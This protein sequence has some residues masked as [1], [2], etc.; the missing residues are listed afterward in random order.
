MYGG[1]RRIY[2]GSDVAMPERHID[3]VKTAVQAFDIDQFEVT[4]AQAAHFLN[5]H[6][7]VCEGL[8]KKQNPDDVLY[9]VWLDAELSGIELR[10]G[11]YVPKKGQEQVRESYFSW[12]GALRYCA[13]AGKQVASSAQWEYASRHDPIDQRDFLYPWGDK[14]QPHAAACNSSPCDGNPGTIA[15]GR[16]LLPVGIF[17]GTRGRYDASSPFGIHDAAGGGDEIVFECERPD[18]TCK[19]GEPCNCRVLLT[20]GDHSPD[21]E[22]LRVDNRADET[23][24][25][26][27]G[28][29]V[30]CVVTRPVSEPTR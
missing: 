24:R 12:E 30:R 23:A 15:S 10:D 7:N 28:G 19:A 25:G 20:S 17:D 5:A 3:A 11:T 26:F 29:A 21:V 22:A 8:D 18:D 4:T 6:G 1:G 2:D 27:G 16:Q 14:W 9:C 13:W